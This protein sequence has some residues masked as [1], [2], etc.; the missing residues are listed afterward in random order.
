MFRK[1]LEARQFLALRK[2]PEG[3]RSVKGDGQ[4]SFALGCE[5]D[6]RDE[7]VM[8]C[9]RMMFFPGCR[10]KAMDRMVPSSTGQRFAIGGEGQ[11]AWVSRCGKTAQ[12][13]ASQEI[14]DAYGVVAAAGR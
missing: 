9:R 7:P 12:Q 14:P 4:Q 5:G 8:P 6:E 10:V 1:R 2:P 3:G 11:G 13:L